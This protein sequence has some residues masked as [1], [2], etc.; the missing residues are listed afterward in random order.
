VSDPAAD[1]AE[2]VDR[3]RAVGG[4]DLSEVFVQ[5]GEPV[6]VA[7][8][9]RLPELLARLRDDEAAALDRLVDLTAV[10]RL[11]SEPRFELVLHLASRAHAHRVRIRAPLADGALARSVASVHPVADWLEREV[12]DLFG[13]GFERHPDLQRILREAD[14]PGYPLRRNECVGQRPGP[15]GRWP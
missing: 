12:H 9:D 14:A 3:L 13:L 5:S 11:G 8:A 4:D 1:T 6:A 2:L 10:D 15:K 7:R